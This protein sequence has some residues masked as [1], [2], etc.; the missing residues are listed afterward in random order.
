MSFVNSLVW[1][2]SSALVYQALMIGTSGINVA[3]CY[4]QYGGTVDAIKVRR[5]SFCHP[6]CGTD[7]HSCVQPFPFNHLMAINSGLAW[8]GSIIFQVCSTHS[9]KRMCEP[10][11]NR[12]LVRCDNDTASSNVSNRKRLWGETPYFVHGN[13]CCLFCKQSLDLTPFTAHPSNEACSM[14]VS[15]MCKH[16]TCPTHSR[17]SSNLLWGR[18]PP[19]AT[20]RGVCSGATCSTLC[21]SSRCSPPWRSCR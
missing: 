21:R 17:T 2:S 16:L 19:C 3:N 20:E 15:I 8:E 7:F 5:L 12:R 11:E 13:A 18:W 9:Y 14:L 6:R 10:Y 4:K 1:L